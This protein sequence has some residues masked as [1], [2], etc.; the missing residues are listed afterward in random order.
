MKLVDYIPQGN[1]NKKSMEEIMEQAKIP[2]KQDFRKLLQEARKDHVIIF[3]QTGYFRPTRKQEIYDFI[4][5]YQVRIGEIVDI[6]NQCYKEVK[7]IK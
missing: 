5:K 7:K 6:L 3:D 1:E 4:E 2:R